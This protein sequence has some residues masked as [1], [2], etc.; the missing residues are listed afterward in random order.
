M[1][2]VDYRCKKC[3]KEYE[4]FYVSISAREKEEPEEKCPHCGSKKKEKLVSKNVTFILS[5]KGWYKDGY[6]K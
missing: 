2:T 5:G 4:V 1:G 3:K 6:G